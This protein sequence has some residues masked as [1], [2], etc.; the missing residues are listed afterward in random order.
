LFKKSSFDH[1]V[2]RAADPTSNLAFILE[3]LTLTKY[4]SFGNIS[5]THLGFA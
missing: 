1:E 3:V 2:L 5:G 4:V